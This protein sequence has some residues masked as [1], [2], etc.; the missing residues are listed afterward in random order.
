MLTLLDKLNQEFHSVL[1]ITTK[2]G[3]GIV[4]TIHKTSRIDI[5]AYLLREH[6]NFYAESPYSRTTVIKTILPAVQSVVPQRLFDYLTHGQVI[7]QITACAIGVQFTDE[8]ESA[9]QLDLSMYRQIPT[10]LQKILE[11][12]YG[13]KIELL[14][15]ITINEVREQVFMLS[16]RQILARNE[17]SFIAEIFSHLCRCAMFPTFA[18]AVLVKQITKLEINNPFVFDLAFALTARLSQRFPN[19]DIEPQFIALYILHTIDMP[20]EQKVRVLL[21][22]SQQAVG[23]INQMIVT[24]QIPNLDIDEISMADLSLEPLDTKNYDL[25]LVNGRSE[26]LPTEMLQ[27]DMVFSG[28]IDNHEINKLKKLADNSFF[29]QK[30]PDFFPI[31]HFLTITSSE[32][33]TD[34]LTKGLEQLKV[35]GQISGT[36]AKDLLKR[37][38][39]SNQL[40]INGVSVPHATAN[41]TNDYEVYVIKPTS[42][43]SLKIDQQVISLFLCILVKNDIVDPGKI[44]TYI[45]KHLAN[46]KHDRLLAIAS[47]EQILRMFC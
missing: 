19:V 26:D 1:S 42:N 33:T 7:A 32:D 35:S 34:T 3:E 24:E 29:K 38:K 11:N 43:N 30:F 44:F 15:A 5:L 27:V 21:V 4:L 18:D 13:A 47:Y 40:V 10:S 14:N 25:I 46:I 9:V 45:Y 39:M 31:S 8:F 6:K 37:E 12:Y 41:I 20:K 28:V 22:F 17:R 2:S 36:A 16:N 23:R